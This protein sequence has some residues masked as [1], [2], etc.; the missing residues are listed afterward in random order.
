MRAFSII[1]M[2]LINLYP[3]PTSF[4]LCNLHV[5]KEINTKNC[6]YY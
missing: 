4:K 2:I 6:L 1:I 3:Y 5:K